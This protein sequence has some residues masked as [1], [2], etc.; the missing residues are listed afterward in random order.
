MPAA[1]GCTTSKLRSSLW[2][3]RVISRRCLRFIL[4]QLFGVGRQLAFLFPST[5]LGFMRN[6]STVNST[7]LGPVG[8]PYTVSPSGSGRCSFQNHAATI[9]TIA[10]TGAMLLCRAETRQ[11]RNAAL[12]AEPCCA[13]DFNSREDA[14]HSSHTLLTQFLS[15]TTTPTGWA[16]LLSPEPVG[17][18]QHHQLYSGLGA[19]TV[20]ESITPT[21]RS[22]V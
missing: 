21:T 19:D 15:H 10:S 5:C 16:L 20:I 11:R 13:S 12:A 22:R 7:R 14:W 3:F 17:W 6:L 9:Y 8:D 18:L 4:C 1:S 2:I